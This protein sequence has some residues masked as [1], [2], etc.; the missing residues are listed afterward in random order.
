MIAKSILLARIP[1]HRLAGRGLF[2]LIVVA[3]FGIRWLYLGLTNGMRTDVFGTPQSP[4][5]MYIA[6]GILLQ[7]PL[8][9]GL[10]FLARQGFF[11]GTD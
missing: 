5:W 7:V 4:R 1:F 8:I 2:A 9:L 6:A 11:V 10:I 3:G